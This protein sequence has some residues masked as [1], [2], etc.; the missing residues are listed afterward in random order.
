MEKNT[1]VSRNFW[2]APKGYGLTDNRQGFKLFVTVFQSELEF[3]GGVAAR[4]GCIETGGELYGLFSHAGR[5]VIMLTTPPGPH[6]IQGVAHFQQDI[7]LLKKNNAFLGNYFGVHYLG[8]WHSHHQLDIKGLSPGDIRSTNS[9]A[10]KNG[11]QRLAQFVLTFEKDRSSSFFSRIDQVHD[12]GSADIVTEPRDEG[13]GLKDIYK[14]EKARVAPSHRFNFI[15]IHSYIYLDAAHG[16]PI[17]CPI[18]VLRGTSPIRRAIM[19][20]SIIPELTKPYT[21]PMN[22]IVF[23]SF[24]PPKEPRDL[25]S[26]LPDR[27]SEDCFQLPDDLRENIRVAYR[28]GLIVLSLPLPLS[29]GTVFVAYNDKPPYRV[30]AVY[31]RQNG[32]TTEPIEVSKK[33]LWSGPNTKLARICE[34]VI[35]LAEG[36][37]PA[38][39]P[40]MLNRAKE[41]VKSQEAHFKEQKVIKER[42][43]SKRVGDE[44]VL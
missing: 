3:V 6:A 25:V 23:D 27:I 40:D 43:E 32:K 16:K 39:W 12:E 38:M 10:Q 29:K 2:S 30:E 18:R 31:F 26:E 44:E 36:E 1:G 28:E 22:R 20:N 41:S 9:I 13:N 11:Y 37:G 21:A 5:P 35:C 33:I 19:R 7:N 14:T 15:R 34:R 42:D 24:S 8:S 17:R 4:R